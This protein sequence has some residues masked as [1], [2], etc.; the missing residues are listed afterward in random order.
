MISANTNVLVRSFLAQRGVKKG[1]LSSFV[2]E[3]VRLRVLALT[4]AGDRA[5]THLADPDEAQAV[6]R[7]ALLKRSQAV[8]ASMDGVAKRESGA[9]VKKP[10]P[11]QPR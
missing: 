1:D 8:R 7:N 10:I 4:L 9:A 3:A 5:S 11:K 2:E 6:M